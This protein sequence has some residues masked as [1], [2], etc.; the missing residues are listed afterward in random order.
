MQHPHDD[1]VWIGSLA[2]VDMM[3][4]VDAVVSMCRVGTKHHPTAEVIEFWVVDFN[5]ENLDLDFTLTDAAN[6]VAELRAEGKTVLLHCY[7]AHS[8]TPS[9]AALYSALHLGVPA[10]KAL[11]EV[12]AVLPAGNPQPFLREAVI[13]IAKGSKK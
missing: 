3:P 11:K 12:T 5:G 9:T 7:A 8:R 1:G 4:D 10:E 6:T 13:R 2:A